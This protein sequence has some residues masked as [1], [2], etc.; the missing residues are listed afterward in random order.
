[1]NLSLKECAL[2]L[3]PR[4]VSSICG[5]KFFTALSLLYVNG[6]YASDVL[7]STRVTVVMTILFA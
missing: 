3:L 1:M 7:T 2:L 4:L 5:D 6:L